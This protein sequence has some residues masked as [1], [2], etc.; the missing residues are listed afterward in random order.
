MRN[1]SE[2]WPELSKKALG[3]PNTPPPKKNNKGEMKRAKRKKL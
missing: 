1:C 3:S 2:C